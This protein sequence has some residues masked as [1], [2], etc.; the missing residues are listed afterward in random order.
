MIHRRC[1]SRQA[2]SNGCLPNMASEPHQ[3]SLQT[4][5]IRHLMGAYRLKPLRDRLLA[6]LLG[7]GGAS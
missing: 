3:A 6:E 7:L 4:H 2:V 5:A 1:S